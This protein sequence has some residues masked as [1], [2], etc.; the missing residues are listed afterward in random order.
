MTKPK[1]GRPASGKAWKTWKDKR[2]VCQ[3]CGESKHPNEFPTKIG[4]TYNK[5][6]HCVECAGEAEPQG[7]FVGNAYIPRGKKKK[8]LP[9]SHPIFKPA[10]PR[11]ID[12]DPLAQHILNNEG[13]IVD[14]EE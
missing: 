4:G 8:R 3:T 13:Q 12:L 7:E 1:R 2:K 9:A 11:E 14:F 10:Q 5:G 6:V